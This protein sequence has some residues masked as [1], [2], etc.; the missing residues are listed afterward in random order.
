MTVAGLGWR[1][2]MKIKLE[3][4]LSEKM[5]ADL[6]IAAKKLKMTPKEFAVRAIT[7]S[8]RQNRVS[9]EDI[10]KSL[11]EFFEKNPDLVTLEAQRY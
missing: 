8:A 1:D 3:V 2:I 6:R 10:T 5:Y 7:R 9:D 4:E 11:N